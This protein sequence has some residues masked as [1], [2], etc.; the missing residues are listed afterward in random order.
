MASDIATQGKQIQEAVQRVA[1]FSTP[2][3]ASSSKSPQAKAGTSAAKRTARTTRDFI[4]SS[5][6]EYTATCSEL[7]FDMINTH[8]RGHRYEKLI[9][10]SGASRNA[11]N[12]FHIAK[13]LSALATSL[14]PGVFVRIDEA[15]LNCIRFVIAG[16]EDTPYSLGL[17]AFD[18][19]LPE[20]YPAVAPQCV[21]ITTGN[22]KCRFNP[23]LY[24]VCPQLFAYTQR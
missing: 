7:A 1:Q 8:L 24:A 13:E 6:S 3:V 20:D 17:F 11:K 21:I 19:F 23:N 16:P 5:Q 14:P 12:K 9:T 18:M 10:T 22:G 15:H 4:A 2:A